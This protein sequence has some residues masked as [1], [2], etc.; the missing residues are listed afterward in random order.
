MEEKQELAKLFARNANEAIHIISE[1]KGWKDGSPEKITLHSFFAGIEGELSGNGFTSGALSGG[2]NEA[3]VEKFIKALGTNNPDLVQAASAVL[4]YATNKAIGEDEL[5]GAAL[6]QWGTKWNGLDWYQQSTFGS[7]SFLSYLKRDIY[8]GKINGIIE[9]IKS[10][11]LISLEHPELDDIAMREM[12]DTLN[13]AAVVTKTNFRYNEKNGLTGELIRFLTLYR[14]RLPHGRLFKFTGKLGNGFGATFGG[15][16]HA[17]ASSALKYD[18]DYDYLVIENEVSTGIGNE[19]IGAELAYEGTYDLDRSY[20]SNAY[21][22]EVVAKFTAQGLSVSTGD[23]DLIFNIGGGAYFG[24][25]GEAYVG[26]NGSTV[27]RWVLSEKTKREQLSE[28]IEN[29]LYRYY[30]YK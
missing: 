17:N 30:T 6:A 15:V 12:I 20:H 16:I 10:G 26:V 11:I 7:D 8:R 24:G 5:A 29:V 25:G 27:K 19:S 3:A 28:F 1:K 23:E 9:D 22:S 21:Q 13:Q 4:G 18:S 2:V 14:N